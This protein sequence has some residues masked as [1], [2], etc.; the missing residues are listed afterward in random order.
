[1]TRFGVAFLLMGGLL[2]S[3]QAFGQQRQLVKE[4]LFEDTALA[5]CVLTY[6]AEQGYEYTDEVR[7]IPCFNRDIKWLGGIERFAEV[8][9]VDV[10][11]NQIADFR[12]LFLLGK[13]LGYLDVHMN[14]IPC[15]QM[16]LLARLYPRAY[17]VG[18][19]PRECVIDFPVGSPPIRESRFIP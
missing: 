7:E 9:V 19:D 16:I 1:M 11:R 6:A 12:P 10:S 17:L 13:A 3:S 14:P 15:T 2:V 4:V 18:F 8:L 5:T